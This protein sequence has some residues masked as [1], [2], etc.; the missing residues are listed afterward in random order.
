VTTA[1]EAALETYLAHLTVERGLSTNTLLAY[2]R[3][4]SRYV[5]FLA[6]R[7]CDEPTAIRERDVEDYLLAVRTGSDGRAALSA[8]SAINAR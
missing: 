3:D 4:L 1:I 8:S 7:G 5:A 2:R 6:Q